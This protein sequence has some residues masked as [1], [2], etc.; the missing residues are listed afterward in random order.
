MPMLD[1]QHED[2]PSSVKFVI[3]QKRKRLQLNDALQD[4]FAINPKTYYHQWS[5]S[6]CNNVHENDNEDAT[7]S[8][9]DV[10]YPEESEESQ[11]SAVMD[12]S[13][14]LDDTYHVSK[15]YV[16]N[17]KKITH[18]QST[19]AATNS[20]NSSLTNSNTTNNLDGTCHVRNLYVEHSDDESSSTSS[21]SSS[22]EERQFQSL[23]STSSRQSKQQQPASLAPASTTTKAVEKPKSGRRVTWKTDFDPSDGTIE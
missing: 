11:S 22:H 5:S 3:E 19:R 18:F 17:K 9:K 7:D 16:E 6:S 4:F 23:P 20:R 13:N 10:F 12:M 8:Q 15:S 14:S 21:S 2:N 1:V